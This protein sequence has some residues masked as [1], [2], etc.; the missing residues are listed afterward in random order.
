MVR[1]LVIGSAAAGFAALVGGPLIQLL[2]RFGLTKAISKEGPDSHLAKAGTA[3]MGGLLMLGT[4]FV[5]TIATN[6]AGE[7]SILLPL[8]V[9]GVLAVVGIFDDLTT[10]QG[11]ERA[12]AH[13]RLGFAAKEV[14]F[15]A[16]GVAASIVAY[17]GLEKDEILIPHFGSY[18]LPAVLYI[19]IG[20]GVFAATTMKP[21]LA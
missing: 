5:F 8:A 2:H 16:V 19:L 17:Y 6:L 9:M 20:T 15:L 13:G 4:V 14:I 21:W 10:L 12:A 7:P 1:A 11:R 18:E 3:T